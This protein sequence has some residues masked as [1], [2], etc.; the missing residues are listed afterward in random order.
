MNTAEWQAE[1]DYREDWFHNPYEEG[2][3]DWMDYEA[4]KHRILKR[5]EASELGE[6]RESA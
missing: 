1:Q 2:S 3:N 4:Q 6:C 5:L